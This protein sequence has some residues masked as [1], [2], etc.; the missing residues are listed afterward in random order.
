VVSILIVV[1]LPA[2]LG[3]KNAKISPRLTSKLMSL[4]AVISPKVFTTFRASIIDFD[5]DT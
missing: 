1:L 4:T 5:L 2:P 3:P